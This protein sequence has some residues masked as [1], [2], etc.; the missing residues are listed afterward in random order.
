M[1]VF[2][3]VLRSIETGFSSQFLEKSPA[4]VRGQVTALDPKILSDYIDIG[5]MLRETAQML[6]D[7]SY[8][9]NTI[10]N[11]SSR[12]TSLNSDSRKNVYKVRQ[13]TLLEAY[14][15][16]YY[17]FIMNVIIFSLF[18][19]V[20]CLI[21][22]AAF[23]SDIIKHLWLVVLIIGVIVIVYTLGMLYA[24]HSLKKR[25]RYDWNQLYF[26]PTKVVQEA[27]S[28]STGSNNNTSK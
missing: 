12:I 2:D 20:L 13:M 9:R 7:A 22:A 18:I 24:F 8:I 6:Q 15:S 4:T 19:T 26:S 14:R 3:L 5:N 16:Q 10:E 23:K 11:E 25:A 28:S 17:K 1:S 21:I 27:Q